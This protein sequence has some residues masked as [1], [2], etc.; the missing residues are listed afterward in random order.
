MEEQTNFL[1]P[2]CQE[3]MGFLSLFKRSLCIWKSLLHIR[4][5]KG[6]ENSLTKISDEWFFIQ[7]YPN[8]S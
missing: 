3:N 1:G 6:D 2:D 5:S 7:N 8:F 4:V